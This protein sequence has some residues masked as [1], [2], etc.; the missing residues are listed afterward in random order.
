MHVRAVWADMQRRAQVGLN[1]RE[2]HYALKSALRIGR[3][4]EIRDRTIEGQH[5][6]IAGLNLLATIIIYL[7][8]QPPRTSRRAAQ[9]SRI[10]HARG[11]AGAHLT[12][13][14]GAYPA[15]W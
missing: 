6:R 11:T 4:G 8:H 7:E 9:A 15:H 12:P 5:F 3:Q 2:A 14:M 1:K 13:R 10:Q